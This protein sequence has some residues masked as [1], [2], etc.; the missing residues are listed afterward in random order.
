MRFFPFAF[1]GGTY[2]I[3]YLVVG[4]GGAGDSSLIN[5][6]TGHGGGGGGVQ[7][8]SIEIGQGTYNIIVGLGGVGTSAPGNDSSFYN[9]TAGGGNSNGASGT[10]Q[11]YPLGADSNCPPVANVKAGGSGAGGAGLS[12]DCVNGGAGGNGLQWVNG[13]YYGGGGG[14]GWQTVGGNGGTGGLGGGGNGG[15][16]PAGVYIQA[17]GG[18]ANTGGAGGGS[19]FGQNQG[20]GGSGV[21]I[22]RYKGAPVA[23][24][25]IVSI[26]EGY[27]YHQFN[28]STTIIFP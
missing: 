10:P 23:S 21:V 7:S 6:Y 14:G 1:S 27:T 9:I 17:Q 16:N 3:D 19:A 12:S 18:V 25:G 28:T 26:I 22:I 24:G 20:N 13:N 11:S 2:S 5:T 15:G 8:G 4:G